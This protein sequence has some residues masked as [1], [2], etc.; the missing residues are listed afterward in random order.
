MTHQRRAAGEAGATV[1]FTE[2]MRVTLQKDNFLTNPKNKQRFIN[3]LSRF[4]Q[5]PNCPTYHAEVEADVLIVETAVEPAR[6]ILS[7]W[8]MIL[9]YL[10]CCA[11]TPVQIASTFFSSQN[12]RQ[13]PEDEFGT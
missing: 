6:E 12:Q 1:T 5:E 10:Y 11:S 9:I 13:T 3:M 8:E 4:F 7:L 2:N